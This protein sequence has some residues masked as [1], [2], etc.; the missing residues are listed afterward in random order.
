MLEIVFHLRREPQ[1]LEDAEVVNCRSLRAFW[2]QLET[3]FDLQNA[4][5]Y[6]AVEEGSTAAKWR[7][8][9]RV[10]RPARTP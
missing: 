2:Q 8:R 10:K 7:K 5:F 3:P 4:T 9:S 1:F 6:G